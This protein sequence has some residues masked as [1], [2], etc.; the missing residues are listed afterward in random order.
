VLQTA[1]LWWIWLAGAVLVV[2]CL[3]RTAKYM[4]A[5]AHLRWDLYPVAHEPRRDHGGSYLEE[6]EW[7]TKPRKKSLMGEVL[8]M[9]EEIL[10]L[11]GVF[12]NN[13]S[14]WWGSMPFHWG[15]YLLLV[16]SFGLLVSALGLRAD[17]WLRLLQIGGVVAGALLAVGAA[18]LLVLRLRDPR[19]RPYTAPVDLM[20]LGLLAVLGVLS[21]AVALGGMAPVVE[22]VA[23][24]VRM[25]APEVGPL[26][27][28]QM[29]IGALFLMYFPATRMI[30]MFA[31]YF[32]YHEVRWDDRPRERGSALDRRL[33]AALNYGVS[34]SAPHVGA[35]RTWAEVATQPPP[36]KGE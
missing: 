36:H 23:S 27:A 24:L 2:G 1:L 22:A 26:L 18:Y 35:G 6:K 34:W 33:S 10:V 30:H 7:W 9:G 28:A 8:V 21:G 25:K 4:R 17:L 3:L 12:K 29:V 11:H 15:L 32:T 5:P 19:L 16:T 20:N 31:K 14:V 13:R